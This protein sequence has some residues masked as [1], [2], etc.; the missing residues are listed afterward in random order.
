MATS[1]EQTS[2]T[3][4]REQ[5]Y[6]GTI[7]WVQRRRRLLL[8][9]GAVVGVVLLGVWFFTT[10]NQRK[11]E[12][13]SQALANARA[14]AESGDL[15][16]AATL[17]QQVIQSYPGT[18]AAARAELSLNQVRLINNQDE[19]AV[20]RLREFVK[21]EPGEQYLPPANALLGAALE[22]S[23]NYAEA[24]AAYEAASGA[25]ALGYLKAGYLIQAARA[26]ELAGQKE[27]AVETLRTVLSDYKETDK[28]TEAQVRLAELTAGSVRAEGQ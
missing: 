8:I 23:G 28:V 6:K 25:A 4:S 27:K 3:S 2:P 12:F 10:A 22:N 17:F 9:A 24:A 7:A 14:T 1:Q 5:T 26:W 16:Q 15:A 19:L 21:S 11:E 18:D 13:A 20:V